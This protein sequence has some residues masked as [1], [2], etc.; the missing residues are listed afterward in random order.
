V[1]QKVRKGDGYEIRLSLICWLFTFHELNSVGYS[2]EK[3][4]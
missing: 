1:A 4:S 3:V 2:V